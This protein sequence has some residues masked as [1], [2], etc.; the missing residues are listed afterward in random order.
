MNCLEAYVLVD[1]FSFAVSLG[2]DRLESKEVESLFFSQNNKIEKKDN[3]FSL[4]YR[5]CSNLPFEYD[6]NK[7]LQAYKLFFAYIRTF[8]IFKEDKLNTFISCYHAIDTF[9][10]DVVYDEIIATSKIVLDKNPITKWRNKNA[11]T[12]AKEKFANYTIQI[13]KSMSKPY[14]IDE[15]ESFFEKCQELYFNY[16]E[17]QRNLLSKGESEFH[18]QYSINLENYIIKTYKLA[19]IDL[20][21]ID[22]YYFNYPDTLKKWAKDED[23]GDIFVNY[24]EI[25]SAL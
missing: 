11:L 2:T 1:Q 16:L 12:F 4:G 22:K 14:K 25:I 18:N 6:K 10:D 23:F 15:L 8:N 17:M 13:S 7:I 19:N 20:K 9:V 24:K 3:K 5:P 21:E